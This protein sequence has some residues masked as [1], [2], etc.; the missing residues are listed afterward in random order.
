MNRAALIGFL[1]GLVVIVGVAYVVAQKFTQIND[2]AVREGQSV[3]LNLPKPP[4]APAPKPEQTAP[5]AEKKAETPLPPGVTPTVLTMTR[6]VTPSE[7]LEPNGNIE[8]T[9]TLTAEGTDPVRAVGLQEEIP[10]GWTFDTITAGAKPDVSPPA[11]RSGVL[12]FAWITVPKFPAA[13]TYRLKLPQNPPKQAQIKGRTLYRTGGPELRTPDVVTPLGEGA[14]AL[15]AAHPPAATER[16][17]TLAPPTTSPA[18]PK[19]PI[20]RPELPPVI[21]NVEEREKQNQER[22][23]ALKIVPT[24][25]SPSFNPGSPVDV[26][27]KVEYSGSDTPQFLSIV[28]ELPDGFS[29][30]KVSG[31]PAPD[32]VPTPGKTG[33][34][35]LIWKNPPTAPAEIRCT[36]NTTAEAKPGAIKAIGAFRTAK[37]DANTAPISI[38][39][40][41]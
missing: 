7:K 23:Q 17:Q 40:G 18:A 8:V 38:P 6:T 1:V 39:V 11:G 37:G 10:E 31:E 32:I 13:F 36:L 16:G 20:Q 26:S 34:F 30:D 25:V 14:A 41:Q 5:V 15:A 28:T 21:I 9:I 22:G 2:V 35:V 4:A 3:P 33:R 27:F 29:F 12:E 24:V 19:P